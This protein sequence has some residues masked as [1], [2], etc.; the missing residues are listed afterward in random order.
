MWRLARQQSLLQSPCQ[1]QV[2]SSDTNSSSQAKQTVVTRLGVILPYKL[3]AGIEALRTPQ[4]SETIWNAFFA[5]IGWFAL[6]RSP[7]RMQVGYATL[8]E[9][10]LSIYK[11]NSNVVQ[12]NFEF[13]IILYG[14]KKS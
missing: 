4:M 8:A 1:R 14:N 3:A 9:P 10:F 12:Q 2:L 5:E 6:I 7:E 13:Q 11:V